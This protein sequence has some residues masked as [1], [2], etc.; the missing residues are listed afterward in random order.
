MVV[1]TPGISQECSETFVKPGIGPVPGS[2]HIA[3][4]LVG[5]LV[6]HQPIAGMVRAGTVSVHGP[7]TLMNQGDILHASPHKIVDNDLVQFLIRV[8]N[9]GLFIEESHY[10]R[11]PIKGA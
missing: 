1:F 8:R 3:V 5:D 9:T 10:F 2:E 7:G 11:C 6:G 4:P